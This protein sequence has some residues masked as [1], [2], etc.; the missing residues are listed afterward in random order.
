MAEK[1]AAPKR[2][3]RPPGKKPPAL[4]HAQT[5]DAI[6][7]WLSEGKTL[8]EFCRQPGM[9]SFRSVYD[10][11]DADENFAARFARAR[12][13]GQDMIAEETIEIIDIEPEYAES[14]SEGG[15]S[16]R[17]DAAFVQWQKNRAEQRLKLLAKWNPK[18]Y[19]DK[20]GEGPTDNR[21]INIEIIKPDGAD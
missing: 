17:R 20:V 12:E 9:P 5:M 15:G 7:D 8:R 4:T 10:W 16:R 3:G 13:I 19:G 11:C 1:K 14:W 21:P 6:I 18:R 2:R